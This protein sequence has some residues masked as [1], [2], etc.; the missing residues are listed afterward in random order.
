M[1][2][3]VGFIVLFFAIASCLGQTQ[4]T[5]DHIVIK[6]ILNSEDSE[7]NEGQTGER[8][9]L[10]NATTDDYSA[11]VGLLPSGK[12]F[13][14]LK[15][16]KQ[17]IFGRGVISREAFLNNE[18]YVIKDSYTSHFPQANSRM[19]RAKRT[20]DSI[21]PSQTLWQ[22]SRKLKY[23]GNTRVIDEYKIDTERFKAFQ[24]KGFDRFK[25]RGNYKFDG[26]VTSYRCLGEAGNV[27]SHWVVDTI[28]PTKR[29]IVLKD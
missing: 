19:K 25:R 22:F 11:E 21:S 15:D 10:V 3:W 13:I 26:W 17:D 27:L 5:F 7:T 29:I 1:K 4:Y 2:K 28:I 12:Y 6:E 23:K 14:Q 20:I 24:S 18:T 16:T 8:F 9:S